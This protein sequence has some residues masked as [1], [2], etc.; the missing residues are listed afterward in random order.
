MLLALWSSYWGDAPS[1]IQEGGG[2]GWFYN[3][4]DSYKRNKADDIVKKYA[5]TLDNLQVDE[6]VLADTPVFKKQKQ[7]LVRNIA[8]QFKAEAMFTSE[9]MLAAIR[10]AEAEYRKRLTMGREMD[11]EIAL[12]LLMN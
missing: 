7:T 2:L 6:T 9:E 3:G 5:E 1:G 10:E 8:R 11:D 4:W 12:L